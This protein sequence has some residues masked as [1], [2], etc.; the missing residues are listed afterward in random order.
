MHDRRFDEE[1]VGA[2]TFPEIG[3]DAFI[4]GGCKSVSS[5]GQLSQGPVSSTKFEVHLDH[6][7]AIAALL[8]VIGHCRALFMVPLAQVGH[9]T[10]PLLF[11]YAVTSLGHQAVMIFF[12]LSG[13]LVGGSVLKGLKAG[14]WTW[15][16]YLA[17]RATRLLIV[18]LPALL[19][20]GLLDYTGIRV[21]GESGIYGGRAET[22]GVVP[23][24]VAERLS[25][26]TFLANVC[27]LQTVLAPTFGSNGPL[28]SLANEF[29]Y[30]IVFPLIAVA[31]VRRRNRFAALVNLIAASLLLIFLGVGIAAYFA[32]W[33]LGV[34]VY[35]GKAKMPIQCGT[36]A[37]VAAAA[38]LVTLTGVS[39]MAVIRS[40]FANDF[41][42]GVG[43]A[44]LI[45]VMGS[46]ASA[47]ER[48]RSTP[49]SRI[50]PF[51][52]TLYLIHLPIV[53]LVRGLA[54]K[55]GLF[56]R[57]DLNWITFCGGSLF[58]LVVIAF[59]WLFARV[60]EARTDALRTYIMRPTKSAPVVKAMTS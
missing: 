38:L 16:G 18:L 33:C 32:V 24:P 45:L 30:Y 36:V 40:N 37:V 21:A 23:A 5:K 7:R 58:V 25:V 56:V 43:T 27:F 15:R 52:Y 53:V 31:W 57:Q 49:I 20:G 4:C 51:S 6:V 22:A 11:V 9:R 46:W 3:T 39:R 50:A 34:F 54:E 60:T 26:R 42:V 8:V 29:W 48:C 1:S 44:V 12:V 28:W 14:T 55:Y 19:L 47:A 2:T 41:V 13:Y 10:L 17:R 35:V 59:A